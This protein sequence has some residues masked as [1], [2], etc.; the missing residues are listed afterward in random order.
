MS[1]FLFPKVA[2]CP[3][4]FWQQSEG[5]LIITDQGSPK[6][7]VKAANFD[8]GVDFFNEQNTILLLSF[9]NKNFA[10]PVSYL[11]LLHCVFRKEVCGYCIF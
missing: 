4:F 5:P 1:F 9:G 11:G 7:Q 2:M 10:F 3:C 8:V 6:L